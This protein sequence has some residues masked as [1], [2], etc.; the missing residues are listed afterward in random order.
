VG[1]ISRIEVLRG[2]QSTLWGSQAIG[3]VIN[4]VTAEPTK[5]F[6]GQV[7]AEGGSMK[8]GYLNAGVGGA[9]DRLVW[10]LGASQFTTDGISAYRFGSEKDGYRNTNLSGRARVIVTDAVS[11]DLRGFYSRGRNDFDGFPP[12]TFNFGDTPEYGLTKDWVGYAGLNFDLFDGALKNRIAFGYTRTDRDNFDP[13]QAVTDKTFD[14]QGQNKRWEYQGSWAITEGWSAT[15]GA[16]S[17]NSKMRTA[18]PSDF[19][20]NPVPIH[21]KTGIDS[22]YGQLQGEVLPGLTLTGG[23]RRDDHDTFGG[24]TTSQVAAA[25]SLNQGQTVVRASWGQGFKAPSLYQLFSDF[26]N[27]ALKPESADSW[28]AGVTH[29]LFDNRFVLGATYFHRKTE[30]QIDFFSCTSTN[31]APICFLNGVR[32]FGAYDNIARTKTHGIELEGTANL[33]ALTLNAN[34][35]W[36]DATNDSAGLNFGKALARR[37]KHQA[38]FEAAYVWPIKLSTSIT[39]QY[40][41][42]SFD[43]VANT[44]VMKSYTLVDLKVSYPISDTFE[45]YGRIENLG[46]E[47]YETTRNYGSIGRAGYVGVR[48]RF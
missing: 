47:S 35:T 12:P 14:A 5:P 26:G 42:D 34:Y 44:Y 13:D 21:A 17:E 36:T 41:G 11:L 29:K 6:E 8:T 7:T 37:P 3:G 31:P 48:A 27:A 9:G 20:P 4:I 32:R 30:N 18:S 23:V 28:D 15:F 25:W 24:H 1:D 38:N 40:V 2:A 19:D 22:V 39:V 33:D 46:D 16:E 45:V 43:D 10:R